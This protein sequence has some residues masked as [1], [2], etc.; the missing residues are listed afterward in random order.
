MRIFAR[1]PKSFPILLVFSFEALCVCSLEKRLSAVTRITGFLNAHTCSRLQRD[2]SRT[3]FCV[4]RRL[5]RIEIQIVQIIKDMVALFRQSAVKAE[6][7][8][9]E[10]RFFKRGPKDESVDVVEQSKGRAAGRP[11]AP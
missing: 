2:R 9:S 7:A 1:F 3:S 4:S 8:R 10:T 6:N 11:L 5:D